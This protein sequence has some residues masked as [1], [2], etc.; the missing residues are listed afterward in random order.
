M[1]EDFHTHTTAWYNA[2]KPQQGGPYYINTIEDH[3]KT[4]VLT[5]GAKLPLEGRNISMDRLYTSVST[6]IWLERW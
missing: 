6:A 4:L 3:V 5:T 2:G 1:M